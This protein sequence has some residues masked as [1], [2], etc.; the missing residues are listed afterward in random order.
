[1]GL[2]PRRVVDNSRRRKSGGIL[3]SGLLWVASSNSHGLGDALPAMI[4]HRVAV[5]WTAI[6]MN[7]GPVDPVEMVS[8]R[9]IS[10]DA[11][12]EQLCI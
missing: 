9:S 4:R 12:P 11:L 3:W 7:R 5:H 1:M 10:M 8:S 6:C 2:G